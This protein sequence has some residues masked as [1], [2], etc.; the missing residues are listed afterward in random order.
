MEEYK[1]SFV[2]ESVIE[3]TNQKV[4]FV[5]INKPYSDEKPEPGR[6]LN[7]SAVK[8]FL[9][10][11]YLKVSVDSDYA[12]ELIEHHKNDDVFLFDITLFLG[13]KESTNGIERLVYYH[14]SV[15]KNHLIEIKD[16]FFQL[17]FKK[18]NYQIEVNWDEEIAPS[19]LDIAFRDILIYLR[20]KKESLEL[21][22]E[23]PNGYL[24]ISVGKFYRELNKKEKELQISRMFPRHDVK[25]QSSGFSLNDITQILNQFK[26]LLPTHISSRFHYDVNFLDLIMK[27]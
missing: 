25:I 18:T 8:S 12:N 14:E 9:N 2:N 20:Y 17:R 10:T 5:G 3:Q 24:N 23:Y 27:G 16:P 26:S 15:S 11:L 22:Q 21:D 4:I 13:M 7:L 6:L 1:V 19:S